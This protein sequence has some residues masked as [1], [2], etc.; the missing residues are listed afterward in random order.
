MVC[1]D[2]PH[3]HQPRRQARTLPPSCSPFQPQPQL[4]LIAHVHTV[5]QASRVNI[6]GQDAYRLIRSDGMVF[7]GGGGGQP[8]GLVAHQDDSRKRDAEEVS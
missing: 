3:P 7:W 8:T 2:A 5:G 1:T 4:T 6:D